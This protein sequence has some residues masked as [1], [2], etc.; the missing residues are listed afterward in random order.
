M[1]EVMTANPAPTP[2]MRNH[3]RPSGRGGAPPKNEHEP[4]YDLPVIGERYPNSF[5]HS[6]D[7]SPLAQRVSGEALILSRRPT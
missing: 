4:S 2:R 7:P 3:P 1:T 6:L 5:F